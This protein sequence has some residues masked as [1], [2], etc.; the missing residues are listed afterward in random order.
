MLFRSR[1]ETVRIFGDTAVKLQGFQ[2][3]TGGLNLPAFPLIM[4][5]TNVVAENPSNVRIT[6]SDAQLTIKGVNLPVLASAENRVTV[7]GVA[8]WAVDG[9]KVLDCSKAFVDFPAIGQSNIFGSGWDK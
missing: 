7:N 5:M 4:T 2:A 6:A 8:T 3:N 1:M 9:D